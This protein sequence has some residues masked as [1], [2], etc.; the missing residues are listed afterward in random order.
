HG[1]VETNRELST[2]RGNYFTFPIINNL[3]INA[4]MERV[5]ETAAKTYKSMGKK[6][7]FIN[8]EAVKEIP[9]IQGFQNP[10]AAETEHIRLW[11]SMN[12]TE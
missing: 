5:G 7:P 9:T 6:Y 4:G 3:I 2:P 11:W 12:W 10:K 1:T 8:Y